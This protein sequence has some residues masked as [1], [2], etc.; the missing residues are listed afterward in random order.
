M[1]QK[2]KQLKECQIGLCNVW[3]KKSMNSTESFR[4]DTKTFTT[5][6]N[7]KK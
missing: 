3:T 2:D 1:W 4:K 5:A 6:L 7:I